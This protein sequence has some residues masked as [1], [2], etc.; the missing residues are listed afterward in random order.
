[1]IRLTLSGWPA[2]SDDVP[3]NLRKFFGIRGHLS[4]SNGLLLYDDRIY[5]PASQ[6]QAI[7][8]NLHVGHQGVTKCR[9]RARSSVFWLGLSQQIQALVRACE[10]CQKFARAHLKEPLIPIPIPDRPWSRIAAD[11]CDFNGVYLVVTDYY[12]RFI[13]IYQLTTL[14]TKGVT[15]RLTEMFAR[16]GLPDILVSDNGPQF[17]SKEFASFCRQYGIHHVTS[18]PYYPQAN[19][20]AERG[21]Q[22]A[23]SIL[24]QPNPML[25]LMSYRATPCASTGFSPAQL[26]MGR[27]IKT[28]VPTLERHLEP[29][30][31]DTRRVQQNDSAAKAVYKEYYDRRHGARALPT[32]RA[33]ARVLIRTGVDK[34]WG[35]PG[36]VLGTAETPRSLIVQDDHGHVVRRNQRHLLLGNDAPVQPEP[37]EPPAPRTA[38]PGRTATRCGRKVIPPKRLDL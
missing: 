26:I 35:N 20:M 28:T 19:G 5:V 3:S 32:P 2:Y 15:N 18:S 13:E 24:R 9:A 27:N 10:H 6:Q 7:L 37:P 4:V 29:Q 33:G 11:L 23:K 12:S 22:I 30:W 21:V 1:V 25:A 31:P 8:A 14:T 34:T 38:S 17:A 16:W 36:T